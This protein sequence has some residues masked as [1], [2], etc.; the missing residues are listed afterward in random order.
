MSTFFALLDKASSISNVLLATT[1]DIA[2]QS[3][4]AMKKSAAVV[5]D[6]AAVS[7]KYVTHLSNDRE[8]KVVM[9]IAIGSLKNK[10]LILL[11][12][13]LLLNYLAP[14]AITPLLLIGAAFLSYEGAEKALEIVKGVHHKP[15]HMD[16]DKTVA[17]AIKTDFILSAEIMVIALSVV[18]KSS[19]MTQF[20]TLL[21]IGTV[22]TVVVYAAVLAIIKIDDLGL[23]LTRFSPTKW[24]GSLLLKNCS[25]ISETLST[26][27]SCGDVGCCGGYRHA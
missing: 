23:F 4:M 27:W 17:S 15:E 19:F 14:W 3:M 25:P 9:R 22:V 13:A 18:A 16:E 1:D 26:Y 12:V 7:P 6:D 2:G 24:L 10:L 8:H 21:F 5:I 20:I 11:P